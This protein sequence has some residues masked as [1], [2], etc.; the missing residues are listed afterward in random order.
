MIALSFS[1]YGADFSSWGYKGNHHAGY[2]GESGYH[3]RGMV[4]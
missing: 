2:A 4:G 3:G 1:V